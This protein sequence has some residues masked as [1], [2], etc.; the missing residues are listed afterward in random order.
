VIQQVGCFLSDEVVGGFGPAKFEAYLKRFFHDLA[1]DQLRVSEEGSGVG[2]F[3]ISV[4]SGLQHAF[5]FVKNHVNTVRGRAPSASAFTGAN[6]S[7]D[8]SEVSAGVRLA[9]K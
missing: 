9:L 6:H 3:G 2:L 1:L 5:E 8:C 7:G 4:A